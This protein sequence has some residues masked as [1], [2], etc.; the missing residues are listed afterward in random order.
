MPT[1]PQLSRQPLAYLAA[2]AVLIGVVA[3]FKGLGSAPFNVDEYYLARSIENVLRSGVPAF[4]CGGFYLRGLIP[5]Y[6]AAALQLCGVSAELAPRLLS[7][8]SSL[9]CLPA[10]YILG[11]RTH[12]RAVGLLAIAVIAISVWEIETARFGRMY[13]PF[14]AVFLWY[15]VFF[16][17][18]TVDRNARALWPMIGLSIIGPLVWEGGAFLPLANLL[19]LFLQ[20]WPGRIL[21]SDLTYLV[22]CILLLVLAAWFVTA[23]F[24]GYVAD[25]WPPGYVR[26]LSQ[27]APDRLTALPLPLKALRQH[28]WWAAAAVLPLIATLFSF[29]WIWGLRSR[30]FAA[31]GLAAMLIAAAAHQFLTVAA[32][33]LLL[34]LTRLVRREELF[35]RAAR[36]FWL[37]I[38]LG[39]IF[40]LAFGLAEA[41]FHVAGASSLPRRLAML[42]Y[43][44]VSFPDFIGVVVR[45]WVRAVPHLAA[46]LLLLLALASYRAVRYDDDPKDVRVLLIILLVMILAAS[47]SHPPRQETR[48]VFFLY[49]LAI[50]IALATMA[51]VA[52][53]LN[54]QA[55]ATCAITAGF[56]LGGFA[57]SEDFQPRHLLH[58]DTP[59]E[60]F[61]IGMT[62][63][64]QSHLVIRDD[65]REISEWLQQ[66][67][68]DRDIVINGV[69]GLD[70]YY[71]GVKY[72]FV[73][74]RDPN[75][76]DWS[77]RKGTIERWGNYPLLT[78]VES[79][80]QVVAAHSS[81][82]LVAFGYDSDQLL[83]SLAVLQPRVA[84]RA[85]NIIVVELGR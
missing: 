2:A 51:R 58:I 55:T 53:L 77:C 61:R 28:P 16:L 13:A 46:G 12:G 45:P 4:A 49:P 65:Y 24:R 48:Y 50:I 41:D 68:R 44:L 42:V 36:P 37:A 85:G 56:A 73:D 29:R 79:L 82:Y 31:A 70:R 66:H 83:Q 39:A 15:L 34:L 25:S 54:R 32:I 84:T 63:D 80:Y 33:A 47:A 9:L 78:S 18:Y 69:H 72:F 3:R 14:Q 30:A 26:S 38:A 11:R 75:F 10:V 67:T 5:Q 8:L 43:P 23:D 57:L 76:A 59:Y 40:W 7:V 21:R 22:G 81:G 62:A 20:R 17:R 60:T 74:E 19:S 71:A 27:A 52:Q 35:T 1:W 6:L 64:M